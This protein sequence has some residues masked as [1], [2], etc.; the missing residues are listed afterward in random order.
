LL[1]FA[2][3]GLDFDPVLSEFSMLLGGVNLQLAGVQ[4]RISLV[5]SPTYQPVSFFVRRDEA[6]ITGQRNDV[7]LV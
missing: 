6:V 5:L 3:N 1:D 7:L 4:D 2:A